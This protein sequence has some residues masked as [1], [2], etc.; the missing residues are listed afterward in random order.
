[1]TVSGRVFQVMECLVEGDGVSRIARDFAPLL[2]ELGAEPRIL[3]LRA[4]E[5]LRAQTMPFHEVAFRADDTVIVHV[6]GPT[7]LEGFLRGFRGR[8]LIYFHN[9]TPPEFFPIGTAVHRRTQAGW[10]QVARLVALGD[11]WLAPSWYNLGCVDALGHPPRRK[12]VIPPVIETM[13]ARGVSADARTLACL[14]ERGER[15]IV[16]V[17]R[18]APHKAQER[19]MDVFEHYHTRIDRRSRL[20][21]IGGATDHPD[22]VARLRRLARRL[23]SCEAIEMTGMVSEEVLAAYYAGADLFL[24]LSEHEGFCLPPM[25]AAAHGVPVM[26]RAAAAVAETV[27]PIG[28]LI[29]RHDRA[30]IAELAHLVLHDGAVRG[31]LRDCAATSLQRM[32]R[33]AVRDEWAATLA[34]VRS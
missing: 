26:A 21:L 19:V 33:A 2:A 30:R 24:G 23:E 4:D 7:E 22:Y 9:I 34:E 31:R 6:W 29:H 18:L 17:G 11:L 32:T 5:S 3:A 16:F 20:H 15:N 25:V 8:K 14:R 28:I 10:A 12:R 1:V 13:D 27:G